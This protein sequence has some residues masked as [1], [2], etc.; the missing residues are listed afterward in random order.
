MTL[1]SLSQGPSKPFQSL[2]IHPPS[3][4]AVLHPHSVLIALA[5]FILHDNGGWNSSLLTS[6]ACS[7]AKEEVGKHEE[8]RR[9]KQGDVSEL[10]HSEAPWVLN[11]TMPRERKKK[12]P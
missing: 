2:F 3:A 5:S 12:S 4:V 1:P 11:Q 7:S 9:A 10:L 6:A 8:H